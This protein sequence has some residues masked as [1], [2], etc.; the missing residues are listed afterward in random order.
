MI[1]VI[2]CAGRKRAGAGSMTTLDSRRV[3]FVAHPE[4]A[5]RE[6]GRVYAH[7]DHASDR[8]GSWREVLL[9]YNASG[10]NSLGLLE[11]SEL[12]QHKAYR[13]LR[14]HFGASNMYILSAG[15]GLINASFLTPDYDITFSNAAEKYAQRRKA[16]KFIDLNLLPEEVSDEIV[17]FDGRDYLAQFSAL[18]C[19]NRA[20]KIVFYN[21][22]TI[23]NAPGC[24]LRRHVTRTRTNWHYE[25]SE[26]FV[27]AG[28]TQKR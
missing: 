8:G 3:I 9:D 25:C 17:F 21:S 16:D 4:Q 18:T 20:K 5:V 15:W 7:P 24:S 2:Q 23:P 13:A 19:S 11:A 26:R 6:D 1:C 12:Y 27:A 22:A 28:V 14:K 10:N